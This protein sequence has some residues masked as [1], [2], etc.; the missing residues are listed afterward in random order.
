MYVFYLH[1]WLG[2]VDRDSRTTMNTFQLFFYDVA[3]S[4]GKIDVFLVYP[5]LYKVLWGVVLLMDVPVHLVS[6]IHLQ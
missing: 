2:R 3:V 4:D 1:G 5:S 6:K